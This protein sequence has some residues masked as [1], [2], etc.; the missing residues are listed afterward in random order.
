MEDKELYRAD[1]RGI[2]HPLANLIN[3]D[4][5]PLPLNP[6]HPIYEEAFEQTFPPPKAY[7]HI[8]P[9]TLTYIPKIQ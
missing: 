4:D 7:L 3:I 1:F 9:G 8:P 6:D 5:G 2:Y